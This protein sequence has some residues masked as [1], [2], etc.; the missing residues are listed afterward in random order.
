[1]K[2]GSADH[3]ALASAKTKFYSGRGVWGDFS[4]FPQTQLHKPILKASTVEI[5]KKA[6]LNSTKKERKLA[7]TKHSKKPKLR[8]TPTNLHSSD[9]NANLPIKKSTRHGTGI[10]QAAADTIAA[11]QSIVQKLGWPLER[12]KELITEKFQGRRRAELS[13]DEALTLLYY[14]QAHYLESV[15]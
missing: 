9:T 6:A 13:D 4:D 11:T 15:P 12:V 5:G 7:S 10:S 3:D 8:Q 2:C 14:L 1:M